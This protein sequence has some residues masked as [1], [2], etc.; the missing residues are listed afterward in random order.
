MF[1]ITSYVTYDIVM[2]TIDGVASFLQLLDVQSV[3]K[4]TRFLV[5]A[6]VAGNSDSLFKVA[7]SL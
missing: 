2:L 7:E 4:N 5:E 1:F 6:R 3:R